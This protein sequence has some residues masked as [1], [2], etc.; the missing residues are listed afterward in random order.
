M[1][2]AVIRESDFHTCREELELT[3]ATDVLWHN[4]WQAFTA[5]AK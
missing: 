2:D 1:P 5:G 4:V 3:P